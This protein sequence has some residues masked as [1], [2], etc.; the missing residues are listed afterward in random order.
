MALLSHEAV[1]SGDVIIP[2]AQTKGQPTPGVDPARDKVVVSAHP[3]RWRAGCRERQGSHYKPLDK[4]GLHAADKEDPIPM[5]D[6]NQDLNDGRS[7]RERMREGDLYI[8]DDPELAAA[9]QRAASLMH[10]FNNSDPANY[11][12]RRAILQEL[13]GFLGDGAEVRPPLWCDYGSQIHIGARTFINYGAVLL[14]VASI[15]I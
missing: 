12:A 10:R 6:E 11:A 1:R 14:D 4:R 13:V 7:M 9:L 3:H 8:A 2:P 15:T 5:S